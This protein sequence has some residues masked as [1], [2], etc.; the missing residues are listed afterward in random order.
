MEWN[1]GERNKIKTTHSAGFYWHPQSPPPVSTSDG[2]G[3]RKKERPGQPRRGREKVRDNFPLHF[4]KTIK[5]N[6]SPLTHSAA[7]DGFI[8]SKLRGI[9]TSFSQKKLSG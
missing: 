8:V 5:G 3:R 9:K 2:N 1:G 7:A 6:F 4:P